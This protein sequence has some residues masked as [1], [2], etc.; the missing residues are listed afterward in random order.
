[1]LWF[2]HYSDMYRG[3]SIAHLLDE[4]GHTGLCFFLLQEMCAEKLDARAG[5]LEESAATFQFHTRVVRQNLRISPANLRR[6]LGV[7]AANGLL[8][9]EFSGNSLQIKM[10][11]LLNL[12]DRDAKKARQ[13]RA[14]NAQNMRL[15]I[16]K[17]EEEDKEEELEK[18]K[19]KNVPKT[20]NSKLNAEI[21]ESYKVGYLRRYGV[22]PVRNASVNAKISQLAKRLGAEAVEVVNFY[23]NHPKTFYVGK[24]HDIGLCLADAEALRTQWAKGKAV[25]Q[26]DLRN[27]EKNME[28]SALQKSILDEG[29]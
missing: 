23:M 3:Q 5:N 20:Q 27:Y 16:D 2:K 18:K 6:L 7:C 29:I 24:M 1:M 10:P 19:I 21:W 17:E 8:S 28:F 12:L 15:D 13:T 26:S 9:F 14:T 25:T 22:E 4:L 11:I